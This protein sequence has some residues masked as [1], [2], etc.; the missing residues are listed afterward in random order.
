MPQNGQSL[1]D[2]FLTGILAAWGFIVG[3]FSLSDWVT[4]VTLVLVSM[5]VLHEAVLFR[6][7]LRGKEQKP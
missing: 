3:H 2:W 1:W 5:K 7:T 4:L 6:R